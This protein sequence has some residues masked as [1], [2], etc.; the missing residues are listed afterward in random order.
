MTA[1]RPLVEQVRGQL[2]QTGAVAVVGPSGFGKS[3][4]VDAVC[5]AW[6]ADGDPAVRLSSAPGDA[7]LAYVP[8]VDLF[9]ACPADVRGELPDLQRSTVDWVLRRVT[10]PE[11]DPATLR[12]TVLACLQAWG[13]GSRLLLAVDDVH[14]WG[15]GSLDVLG[16][17]ARRSR[18]SVSLLAALRPD[19]PPPHDVLGGGA[20]EIAVPALR[21]RE[22]AA[23]ARSRGIPLRTAGR[24]HAATGGNPRLVSDIAAGLARAGAPPGALDARSPAPYARKTLHAWLAD[25]AEPAHHVLLL[26]ALAA[27]PSLDVVRRAAGPPADPALTAAEAAGLVLVAEGA[28]AFPAPVVREAVVAEAEEGAVRRA[29]QALAEASTEPADQVWHEASALAPAEIPAR[30]LPALADAAEAARERGDH[31]RATEFGLLV[32]DRADGTRSGPLVAAAQDAAAAGRFD[33]A[34]AA[35]DRLNRTGAGPAACARV[36]LAVVDA[37]GRGA[38][39]LEEMAARALAEATAAEEP[40]LISA[41]HLGLARCAR[42]S[43]GYRAGTLAHARDAMEWADLAEDPASRAAALAL[44]AEIEQARGDAPDHATTLRRALAAGATAAVRGRA[45]GE[46]RGTGGDPGARVGTGGTGGTGDEPHRG[47][48]DPRRADGEPGRVAVEFALAEDRRDEA[49]RLLN[50]LRP[51]VGQAG[52]PADLILLLGT[53]VQVHAR[54]GD[55]RT[56]RGEARRLLALVRDLGASP[57]PAWYAAATAELAGGTLEQALAFAELG[58]IA[59]EEESDA[60]FSAHCLHLSGMT[61]LLLRDSGGALAD[62]LRVR[63][64]V[65]DLAVGDPAAIRYDADLAEALVATGDVE[66]ATR[67][68]AGARRRAERLERRGVLASLDRAEALC[69]TA[70]GEFEVAEQLLGRARDSFEELGYPLEQGRVLLAHS[71][72]EQRRRRPARAR[73]LRAAAGAVFH[74]AG[75]PLWEP[76]GP[77]RA[78]APDWL[79]GLTDAEKRIVE[80]VT[81][82]HGNRDVAAALYVSVK[83]VEAV[84]TRIYRKLGVRSRVQLVASATRAGGHRAGESAGNVTAAGG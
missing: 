31:V 84:L 55:G 23:V 83:T 16:F 59:S 11:P 81:E 48:R 21:P 19:G 5:T 73:E 32:V 25:L 7:H 35:L 2:R 78:G 58:L 52:R 49:E 68:V 18:G 40:V 56:A 53:A 62:L 76:A 1:R 4:V 82:G 14:W 51:A 80:L 26:A 65:R 67:T 3:A 27:D 61:R 50:E 79:A 20:V 54:G 38:G 75:A 30:L 8:L 63:D 44:T 43:R 24:I 69:R 57:G 64:L 42:I 41:A 60:V 71:S 37:A 17:A 47:V 72:V 33:L 28:V 34:C 36:R 9:T 12:V 39:S 6:R 22:T 15:P 29:H 46:P 74:R 13:R 66:T 45:R 10:G 77:G 70:A